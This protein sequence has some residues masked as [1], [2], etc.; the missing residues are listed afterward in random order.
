MVHRF[1]NA[2]D[3]P[4]H[5]HVEVRPA[6]RME[7]LFETTVALAREGRTTATGMPHPLDL[8]LFI[9]EFDAEVRAPFVPAAAV[10]AV[11][12]PLAWIARRRD[13]DFRY[14]KPVSGAPQSRRD[15]RRP[16]T[17]SAEPQRG[18]GPSN[19]WGPDLRT[20]GGWG[21][22][23]HAAGVFGGSRARLTPRSALRSLFTV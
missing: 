15:S 4:A 19:Y 1:E 9:H 6:L 22:P 3:A 14:R 17:R 21:R 10:R 7:E 18:K 2:G 23:S 16:P 20:P 13:L 11:M 12:A 5:V 8:A